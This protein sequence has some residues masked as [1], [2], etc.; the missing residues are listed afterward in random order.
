MSQLS[1]EH[2]N[3]IEDDRAAYGATSNLEEIPVLSLSFAGATFEL[4]CPA[5]DPP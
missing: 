3:L 2:E 4:A 1:C 5:D